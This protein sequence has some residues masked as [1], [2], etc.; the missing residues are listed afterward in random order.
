MG[1]RHRRLVHV[2]SLLSTTVLSLI[3]RCLGH[4]FVICEPIYNNRAPL[5]NYTSDE[6]SVKIAYLLKFKSN[7]L[8]V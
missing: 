3:A 4:L 1:C 2:G 7:F 6:E 8:N 5:Y